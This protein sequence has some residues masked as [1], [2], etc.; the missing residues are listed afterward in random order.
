MKKF[1]LFG[2]IAYLAYRVWNTQASVKMFQYAFEGVRF[3]LEGL[4]PIVYIKLNIYN[5]NR[6]TVPVQTV[7]GN[8]FYKGNR[9][10]SFTNTAQLAINGQENRTIELKVRLSLANVLITVLN[11]NPAKEVEVSGLIRTG[12]F[13]LPFS[14]QQSLP[15]LK[16]AEGP[17]PRLLK[18]FALSNCNSY[19][20]E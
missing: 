15:K 19:S 10:A 16:G 3:T 14:Y 6:T 17:A 8:V 1:F 7:V 13:D 2:G 11:K 18:P 12:F 5:P 9:I 4:V 20:H